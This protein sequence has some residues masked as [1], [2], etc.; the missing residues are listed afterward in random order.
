[1]EERTEERERYSVFTVTVPGSTIQTSITTSTIELILLYWVKEK[2]RGTTMMSEAAQTRR[3]NIKNSN[4]YDE[5]IHKIYNI[6]IQN[7]EEIITDVKAKIEIHG[8]PTKCAV[9]EMGVFSHA[10]SDGPIV[11]IEEVE[12]YPLSEKDKH[13]M[14]LD[15]WAAIEINWM[16]DALCVF[17]GCNTGKSFPDKSFAR[18]ISGLA[19]FKD[20]EVWGQ[21]TSAY[22]S[23]LPDYRIT[24]LARSG[25]KIKI[26]DHVPLSFDVAETYLVGGNSKDAPNAL[27]MNPRGEYP[28]ANFLNCYKNEKLIR[29]THQGFFNDHRNKNL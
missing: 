19:N 13:Q 17:Y 11:Y 20:V 21:S 14:S 29:S 3:K 24:N 16:P 23:F 28:K 25:Y 15:G 12:T 7:L 2:H 8:G 10:G 27:T 18:N 4:W 26:I 1:M 5:K 9:R 6:P 22:P